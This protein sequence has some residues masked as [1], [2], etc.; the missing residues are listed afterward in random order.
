MTYMWRILA[1]E[2]SLEQWAWYRLTTDW[3]NY[4]LGVIALVLIVQWH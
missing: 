1:N 2:W 4:L 3:T